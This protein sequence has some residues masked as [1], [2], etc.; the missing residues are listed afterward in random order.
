[1]STFNEIGMAISAHESWKNKL[2]DAIATGRSESTPEKVSMDDNCSFGKWLHQRIDP[3]VKSSPF[4]QKVLGMHAQFHAAA[5]QI[6]GLAIEGRKNEA[7]QLM[8]ISSDFTKC[9]TAL[10]RMLKEWQQEIS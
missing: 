3:E 4:Y 9:S 10:T 6:L 7:T 8:G 1:M 2:R 5:G